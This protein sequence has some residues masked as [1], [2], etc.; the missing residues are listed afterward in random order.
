MKYGTAS[1][2]ELMSKDYSI[3]M[4]EGKKIIIKETNSLS[5][6]KKL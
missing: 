2:V 5:S 6:H 1:S 3:S 4:D